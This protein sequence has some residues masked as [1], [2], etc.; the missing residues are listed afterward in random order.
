MFDFLLIVANVWHEN[1]YD[2]ETSA[3]FFKNK[4]KFFKTF[5]N[6]APAGGGVKRN[7]VFTINSKRNVCQYIC[8]ISEPRMLI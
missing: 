1:V 5:L 4:R 3:T 8:K 6:N 2:A 7:H